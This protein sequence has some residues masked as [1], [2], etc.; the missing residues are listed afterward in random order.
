MDILYPY[1]LTSLILSTDINNFFLFSLKMLNAYKAPPYFT[2]V[3]FK[4]RG[5][6]YPE[7]ILRKS[8]NTHDLPFIMVSHSDNLPMEQYLE[9]HNPLLEEA[10]FVFNRVRYLT[11]N[12]NTPIANVKHSLP[13]TYNIGVA[14]TAKPEK[15]CKSLFDHLLI[16]EMLK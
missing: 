6:E 5:K 13:N 11:F 9:L 8:I 3:N 12:T 4:Y 14:E 2:N 16:K 10:T 7:P 15:I 1:E